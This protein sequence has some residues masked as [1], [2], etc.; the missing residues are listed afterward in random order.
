MLELPIDFDC[1]TQG[2][3]SV[4][5]GGKW[6]VNVGRAAYFLTW[7]TLIAN[8]ANDWLTRQWISPLSVIVLVLL[9]GGTIM[10]LL[11]GRPVVDREADGARFAVTVAFTL[12]ALLF[13]LAWTTLHLPR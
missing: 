1:Q 8:I 4:P 3:G 11:Q 12:I 2:A 13:I 5:A 9:G 7:L 10:R 6:I